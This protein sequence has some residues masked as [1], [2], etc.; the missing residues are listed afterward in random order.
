FYGTVILSVVTISTI[1]LEIIGP[2]VAK[3]SLAQAG[4]IGNGRLDIDCQEQ[5]LEESKDDNLL[6]KEIHEVRKD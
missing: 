4:E 6:T 3:W 1:I 2:I 5:R